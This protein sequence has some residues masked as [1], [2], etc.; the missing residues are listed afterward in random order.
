M[1][2]LLILNW[3]SSPLQLAFGV[4]LGPRSIPLPFQIRFDTLLI[5]KWEGL[6]YTRYI[7]LLS[8]SSPKILYD[9]SI[10]KKIMPNVTT[11]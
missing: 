9:P 8:D 10:H 4:E 5:D 11:K 6:P 2:D 1:G 3:Q 7:Q